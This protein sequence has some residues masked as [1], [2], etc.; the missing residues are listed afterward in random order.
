MSI[1]KRKN[2]L[3]INLSIY[4]TALSLA[5]RLNGCRRNNNNVFENP[6]RKK[7]NYQS[8]ALFIEKKNPVLMCLISMTRLATTIMSDIVY[9][10][11]RPMVG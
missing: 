7:V 8:Q 11:I 3:S 2:S 5:C 9:R 4:N 10:Y 1:D 6:L